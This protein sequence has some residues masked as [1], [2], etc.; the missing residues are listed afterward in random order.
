LSVKEAAEEKQTSLPGRNMKKSPFSPN[1]SNS[2]RGVGFFQQFSRQFLQPYG[3]SDKAPSVETVFRRLKP[4]TCEW[5][6]RPKVALSELS[7]TIMKNVDILA[8]EENE[9]VNSITM[10]KF[11]RRM[12]P[13]EKHLQQLH[14]DAVGNPEENNVVET[15][16][17]L[18]KEDEEMDDLVDEMFRV[19]GA[20]FV[21]AIQIIVARTV[22]RNPETYAEIVEAEDTGS[23]AIFKKNAD[24]ESMR[25]FIVASVIG[26]SKPKAQSPAR[27]HLL[28]HFDSPSKSPNSKEI[29]APVSLSSY[30]SCSSD[31]ETSTQPKTKV[32]KRTRNAL[33]ELAD[34]EL[35]L[36]PKPKKKKSNKK[37][38]TK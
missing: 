25:D 9:I 32:E 29:V 16:K 36:T 24:I 10:D 5:L 8:D 13:V 30:A 23:D 2:P 37:T 19:G 38:K 4:F 12:K 21:T 1:K 3:E 33:E 14:K 35:D 17:F 22:I 18:F 34:D 26:K 6:L 28:K 15:L 31:E 20:L 27:R 11:A 7:E